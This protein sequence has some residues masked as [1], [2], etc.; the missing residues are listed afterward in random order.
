M[1]SLLDQLPAGNYET[2]RFLSRFL[3]GVTEHFEV[4]KMAATN[5][6][7]VFGP[8]LTW[9]EYELARSSYL[10]HLCTP[11]V[12]QPWRKRRPLLSKMGVS[13]NSC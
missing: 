6:A 4:N 8:N 2:I 7:I 13:S 1:K 12:E 5:L 10:P 9:P 11:F 3:A